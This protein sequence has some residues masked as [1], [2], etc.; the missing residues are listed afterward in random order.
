MSGPEHYRI[1]VTGSRDWEDTDKL[2]YQLGLAISEG[3]RD[4]RRVIVVHGACPSGADAL[5]DR[6]VCDQGFEVEPHPAD[7]QQ[8][9][10]S[11]GFRRNA[12]MVALGADVCLAFIRNGSKGATHCADAAEKAGIP[13][14]RFR[15]PESGLPHCGVQWPNLGPAGGVWTCTLDA[16]HDGD[17]EAHG[18]G[19][20]PLNDRSSV[21]P[22]GHPDILPAGAS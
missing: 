5:A 7:W 18:R 1:L 19:G 21:I 13:V 12:E 22:Q 4:G 10:K 6:L 14:R 20:R 16:G 9:G 17:H 2:A 11:A 8:F 15:H 3:H